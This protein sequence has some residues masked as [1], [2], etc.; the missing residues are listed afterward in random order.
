MLMAAEA[1][2]VKEWSFSALA[3]DQVRASSLDERFNLPPRVDFPI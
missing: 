1:K 2:T 3:A